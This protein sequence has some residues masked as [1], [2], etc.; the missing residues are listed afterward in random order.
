MGQ[1]KPVD[2]GGFIYVGD[3][4][5]K[6]FQYCE[7][8]K[9]VSWYFRAIQGH[10]GGHM[11]APELMGHVA[12]PYKWKEFLFHRG[13]SYNVQPILKSGL[14]AG[15]RGSKQGGQTIFFT[16][17]NP[18]G[19]NPDEEKLSDDL[20]KRRKAQY[21]TNQDAVYRINLA[22]AQDKGLQFWQT[23]SHAIIVCSTVPVDCIYKWS[24]KK[25]NGLYSKD[26]IGNCSSSSSRTHWEVQL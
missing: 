3:R 25:E 14:I 4:Q 19:P 8:S 10:T 2:S 26:S 5:W 13:C 23:R 9:S 15:G 21:K 11:I 24:L 7:N 12:L 1:K 6:E 16:P 22:R 18:F 17:L 20:S